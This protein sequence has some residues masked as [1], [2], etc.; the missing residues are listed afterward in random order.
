MNSYRNLIGIIKKQK[1]EHIK[2]LE[3]IK[4]SDNVLEIGCGQGSFLKVG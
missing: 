3:M 2:S 4:P 1:W